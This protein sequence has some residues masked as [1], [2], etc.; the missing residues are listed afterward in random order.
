MELGLIT[1]MSALH[2]L[3]SIENSHYELISN[4]KKDFSIRFITPSQTEYVDIPMV[5]V[6]SGGT[7]EMF[8]SIYDE[9]PQP[10]ILLT[11]GLHNSLAA[12]LEMQSWIKGVG[13][14]SQILH[15]KPNYL[16]KRIEALSNIINV[17]KKLRKS[18]IG[19][20]G[21]PSPWLIASDV[22]YVEVKRKWGITYKNIEISE[23]SNLLSDIKTEEA[24]EIA[25]RFIK[26]SSGMQEPKNEE[27]TEA[28]R[29][30]LA[31]KKLCSKNNLDAVTLK[32]FDVLERHNTTGCLALSLLNNEGIISGCEGDCQAVFS[33]YIAKLLTGD[34]PFMSNPSLIDHET[35]EIIFAHCTMATSITENYII[36]NHFESL[37]G[38]GIQG[39]VKKG[40]VTIFKCGGTGLNKYF[41]SRGELLENL[42]NSGMCRTQLRIKLDE[43]VEYFFKN[44]IANHHLII[45]GDHTDIIKE[46]MDSMGCTRVI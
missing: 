23:L 30:Y 46:L 4:L 38:I 39:E 27:V 18:T 15:G 37:K 29:V 42:N 24:N 45:R 5:F 34:I 16:K 17:S 32:C 25:C 33:M 8:K 31:M 9:L 14:I 43:S 21:F 41:L 40:P 19:V 44:T 26:S 35:N 12:S 36:R 3:T 1:I 28:A 6:G 20:V 22:D 7:E 11:D 13:G 2:D 10:I